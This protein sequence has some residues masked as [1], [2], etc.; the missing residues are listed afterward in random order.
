MFE[1]Q[2]SKFQVSTA[3]LVQNP[4]E[5]SGLENPL[6]DLLTLEAICSL[7]TLEP[8]EMCAEIP[9]VYVVP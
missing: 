7:R 3:F 4:Q 5:M 1:V 8:L 9:A 6:T 2:S